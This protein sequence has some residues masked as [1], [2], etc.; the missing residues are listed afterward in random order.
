MSGGDTLE[1]ATPGA[2]AGTIVAG[3]GDKIVLDGVTATSATL[4]NGTLV[5]SNG[6]VT[7]ASL[8]LSGTYAG[9][10]ITANGSI[11]TFGT[12]VAP[13][14]TGTAAGQAVTDAGTVSPFANVTIQ[15]PNVGQT[16]TVTITLS[17]RPTARCPTWAAAPTTPPPASTPPPEPPLRSPLTCTRCCSRRPHIR[18]PPAR[19][20]PRP[21]PSATP[22]ARRTDRQRRDNHGDRHRRNRGAGDRRHRA[23]PG[24]PTI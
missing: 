20:R 18:S 3:I 21:S 14:I 1:L 5:V 16:E 17:A 11:L 13:V 22:T 24:L 8:A 15:D 2:F 7:V 12:A 10:S 6:S 4:N 19:P 9:E 23:G